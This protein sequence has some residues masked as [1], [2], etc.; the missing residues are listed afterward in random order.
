[1]RGLGLIQ[2]LVCKAG[3]MPVLKELM[4]AGYIANCTQDV[5]LRFVPPLDHK[6][7]AD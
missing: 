4:Q 6:H 3:C 2:G 1:M 5:V 7:R